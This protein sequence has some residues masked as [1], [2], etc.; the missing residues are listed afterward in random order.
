MNHGMLMDKKQLDALAE[1]RFELAFA[2]CELRQRGADDPHVLVGAGFLAQDKD[3]T[4]LLRMAAHEERTDVQVLKMEFSQS[5]AA[6]QIIP[7]TDYYD[8]KAWTV[9]GVEWRAERV[10]PNMDYGMHGTAARIRLRRIETR[11][12]WEHRAERATV[13]V[14]IPEE[15]GLP[16]HEWISTSALSGAVDKFRYDTG[17]FSWF[18]HKFNGQTTVGFSVEG[19]NAE[20][21]YTH[22]L[23]ALKIV[24]GR[25]IEPQQFSITEGH[26]RAT[27]L[28]SRS[29]ST[30]KRRLAPP[31]RGLR[32]DADDTHAFIR[33]F[34]E[35]S[36]REPL[37]TDAGGEG[38]HSELIYRHWHRILRAWE[39]DLENS[40]LVLSVAIE[41]LIKE[42]FA[43]EHDVDAEFIDQLDRAKPILEKV[44]LDKRARNCVLASIGNAR[45]PRVGDVLRRLVEQGALHDGHVKA[46][47]ALRN[48]A[49]HGGTLA[50]DDLALQAYIDRFHICL[51]LFYRLV[52]V[53]IGYRGHH[54]DYSVVCSPAQQEWPIVPFPP[55]PPT[56]ASAGEAGPV[57][58]GEG[59]VPPT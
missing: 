44:E 28:A 22:F 33:A 59:A 8:L 2:R 42:A 25:L 32:L 19:D 13:T 26:W 53:I 39:N 11:G 45:K 20:P 24:L 21:A 46:W 29:E 1:G 9:S 55:V 58:T 40:A 52:F 18:A 12:Q 37:R 43:S 30:T 41:G 34:L 31:V 4:L 54:R 51:D 6:G 3:G 35:N 7:E 50:D 5:W 38:G 56:P 36:T 10:S 57:P 17:Q 49:A 47:S 48:T 15:L 27:C 16:W 14:S 23:R